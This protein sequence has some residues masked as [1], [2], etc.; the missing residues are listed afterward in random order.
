MRHKLAFA[1]L[2]GLLAC[3]IVITPEAWAQ[4]KQ[5]DKKADFLDGKFS[6][7]LELATDYVFRGESETNDGKIPSIKGS[8]T[9]THKSGVYVGLYMA[10]NLYP[11]S[12]IAGNN[13]E[14]NS[15][16]GPYL[17]YAR[18]NIGGSG[19]NYHGF[20]FQYLYPGEGGS[21]SDYL[22]FFNYVD[23]Q[24]GRANLKLEYTPTLTDWFGVEGLH[25][26]NV[27]VLPSFLLP[28]G[29]TLSGAIGRQMFVNTGP[30]L[31]ANGDG[32]EELNWWHWNVGISREVFR[33]T[34]DLRYH[35]TDIRLGHHDLYGFPSNH[36]IVDHRFV[37]AVSRTF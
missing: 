34:V 16:V 21:N 2:L 8:V 31:D 17:G 29:V 36:Q 9:W 27:A 33:F 12:D 28:Y 23:R 11:G 14:I 26:H 3:S 18:S 19:I 24:F 35:D 20:L 15:I 25:S 5:Q 37:V 32:R 6:A 4:D 7:W 13:P 22:E 30:S 10:N 1:G